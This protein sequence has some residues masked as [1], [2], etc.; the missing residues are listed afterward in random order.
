MTASWA[1]RRRSDRPRRSVTELNRLR[2]GIN[3]AILMAV[4]AAIGLR[5]V[6]GHDGGHTYQAEFARAD[7]AKVGNDVRIAGIT[8]GEVTDV[9]LERDRIVVTFTVDEDVTLGER[10]EAEMKVST[11]VGAYY[12]EIAPRGTGSLPKDTIPLAQTRSP[13]TLDRIVTDGGRDLAALDE[14]ALR[15][16]LAV[17]TDALG[18]DG[19]RLGQV[20]DGVTALTDIAARRSDQIIALLRATRRATAVVSG[21]REQLFDLIGDTSALLEELLARRE[22]IENLLDLAVRLNQTISGALDDNAAPV[23]AALRDLDVVMGILRRRDADIR[24]SLVVLAP[25]MRYLSATFGDGPYGT[26][27]LAS[28]LPDNLLCAVHVVKDCS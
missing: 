21:S 28:P 22:A 3:T 11:L 25:T 9:E 18:D 6:A 19:E 10:T 2:L 20:L 7:G 5:I 16:S 4:L 24:R 12:L 15:D 23:N 13:Y 17:A 1:K 27:R 26:F 14:K 8:V